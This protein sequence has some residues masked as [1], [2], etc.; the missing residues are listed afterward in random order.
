MPKRES[1]RRAKGNLL[2]D[3]SLRGHYGAQLPR[4]WCHLP[5][6][7]SS[8]AIS[9][10][11]QPVQGKQKQHTLSSA[12]R[13]WLA[14][15]GRQGERTSPRATAARALGEAATSTKASI[16]KHA[17]PW[18]R[19]HTARR[20]CGVQSRCFS[21]ATTMVMVLEHGC[22]HSSLT[23]GSNLVGRGLSLNAHPPAPLLSA[24]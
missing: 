4:D 3:R 16:D 20:S 24:I 11:E 17:R 1:R 9:G 23:P 15:T 8:V 2:L 5:R 7:F 13:N 21:C 18:G 12:N 22:A 6:P 10:D 19:C 14:R